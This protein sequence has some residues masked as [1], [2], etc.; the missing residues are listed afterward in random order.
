[1]IEHN[2]YFFRE[3]GVILVKKNGLYGLLDLQT[4]AIKTP[5]EYIKITDRLR[6][7]K[8]VNGEM[9]DVYLDRQ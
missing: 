2:N 9:V 3:A 1:M 7:T 8:M 4:L 5:C 6:A